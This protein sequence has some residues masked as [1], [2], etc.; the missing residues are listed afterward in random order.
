MS[1]YNNFGMQKN[2]S[3]RLIIYHRT[4]VSATETFF[5][6]ASTLLP[7]M[8]FKNLIFCQKTQNFVHFGQYGLIQTPGC[9]NPP[10]LRR[11]CYRKWPR[12][13]RVKRTLWWYPTFWLHPSY[14]ILIIGAL[15]AKSA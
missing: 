12:M 13:K 14:T 10:P 2:D 1:D 9:N 4:L 15:T 11:T 8:V 6:M 5:K 7:K 3:Y